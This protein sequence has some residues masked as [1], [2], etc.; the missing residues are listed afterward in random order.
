[1]IFPIARFPTRAPIPTLRGASVRLK[2]L[3]PL[4]VLGPSAQ[5]LRQV[6]HDTGA[7]DI[8]FPIDMAA[9]IGVDL[10]SAISG[11]AVGV[12]TGRPVP[13]LY[14]PVI[15]QLQDA[16]EVY[17]WRAVVGFTSGTLRFP[18]FGIAGGL[19]YFE[20]RIN[21][22]RSEIMLTAQASLPVT[23]DAVP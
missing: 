4:L 16:T 18:L 6:L 2:S 15:L 19:E 23:T 11:A 10:R 21:F 7:D 8:V 1:M 12:G 5:E 22:V 14:A 3:L 20:S 17:R 9:R 13:I